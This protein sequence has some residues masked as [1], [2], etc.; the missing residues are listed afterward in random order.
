MK[1]TLFTASCVLVALSGLGAAA[2]Y[3][4]TGNGDGSSWTDADNWTE[5]GV[6]P[7][8]LGAGNSIII[9]LSLIHI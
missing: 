3:Q 4:W 1:K 5:A 2:T 6:P 7:T 9:N 8:T